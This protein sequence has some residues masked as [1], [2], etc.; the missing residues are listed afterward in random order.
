MTLKSF[1]FP[2]QRGETGFP[3]MIEGTSPVVQAQINALFLTG[4]GERRHRPTLGVSAPEQ[5]FG[6]ISQITKA[7]LAADSVRSLREWVPLALL[8]SIDVNE[9]TK[10]NDQTTLYADVL[11]SVAGEEQS[12]QVPMATAVQE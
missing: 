6:E 1:Q 4:K 7:R 5:V 11:Y 10:D 3:A 12:Q 9:G 8:Q 2:F